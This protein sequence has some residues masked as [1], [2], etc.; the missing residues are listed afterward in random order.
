[1]CPLA[2]G[3]LF[4]NNDKENWCKFWIFVKKIIHASTL[5]PVLSQQIRIR[6]P[7]VQ[8]LRFSRTQPNSIALFISVKKIKKTCGGGKGT[9]ANSA[10]WVFNIFQFC[11]S[12]VQLEQN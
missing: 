1:M 9:I 5:L 3:L 7:S 12:V 8:Y 10:L 2:F 11:N 6:G 4:G